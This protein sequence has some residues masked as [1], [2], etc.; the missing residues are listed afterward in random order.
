MF[1]GGELQGSRRI[2]RPGKIDHTNVLMR[3]AD[4]MDVQKP[5]RQQRARSRLGGG[6]S[7]AEQFHVQAA[8]LLGF[9]QRGLFRVFVEFDVATQRQPFVQFAMVNHQNLVRVNDEDCDCEINFFVN[10]R[11]SPATVRA[12]AVV[13]KSRIVIASF[14]EQSKRPKEN[15]RLRAGGLD[16]GKGRASISRVDNTETSI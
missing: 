2:T 12:A 11:H 3:S 8:L 5:G 4:P 10:V 6:R 1:C 14:A 13:V 16:G 7:F 9:A 15:F